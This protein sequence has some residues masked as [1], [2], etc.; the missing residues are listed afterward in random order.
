M[1]AV[2][3][4]VHPV[5]ALLKISDRRCA[6]PKAISCDKLI[7]ETMRVTKIKQHFNQLSC[8]LCLA[9]RRGASSPSERVLSSTCCLVQHIIA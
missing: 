5:M 4:E 8:V 1:S 7:W 3:K 6:M 2:A 9:G